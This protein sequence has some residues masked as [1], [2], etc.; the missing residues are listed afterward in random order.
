MTSIMDIG[1]LS[2]S[3]SLR[4]KSIELNGIGADTL[5]L[6]LGMF[7]DL[8]KAIGMRKD[9]EVTDF[10]KFGPDICAGV[11]AVGCGMEASPAS[12]EKIKKLK[13]TVGEQMLLLSPILKMTFPQGFHPFVDALSEVVEGADKTDQSGKVSVTN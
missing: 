6:L 12:V 5:V 7:P 9:M 2:D 1:P 3:V 8:Y 13:L 4:G 11:I 10:I